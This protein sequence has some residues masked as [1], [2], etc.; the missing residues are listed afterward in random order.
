MLMHLRALNGALIS[1]VLA[2]GTAGA[3]SH[4]RPVFLVGNAGYGWDKPHGGIALD[5]G[6]GVR[7]PKLF[8]YLLPLD[9]TFVQGRQ[10]FRYVTQST[11]YGDQLCVDTQTNQYVGA[12]KCRAP[13]STHWGGA[14]E[15]NF[16][17]MGSDGSF[18]AGVGYRTGYAS[19][20][21]GTIG[22]IGRAT[23]RTF[24]LARLSIGSGYAVLAIGGHL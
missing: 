18:F 24:G 12:G 17:P 21:Y 4:Q 10:N 9:V 19:T 5:G 11:I 23:A 8:A 13:V 14:A 1:L 6:F 2:A 7:S 15:A 16:A 3:Q 20:V 22:Y